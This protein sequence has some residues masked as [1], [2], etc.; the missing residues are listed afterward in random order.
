VNDELDSK[1][2]E[3]KDLFIV[4]DRLVVKDFSSSES[5]DTKRLKDSLDLAFKT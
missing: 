3:N 4:I 5:S 2:L 1:T